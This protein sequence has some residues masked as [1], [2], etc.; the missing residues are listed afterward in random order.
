MTRT[1]RSSAALADDHVRIPGARM[2]FRTN[3]VAPPAAAPTVVLVHGL[4]IS[5]RYMEPL[6]LRL[7]GLCRV[8][9]V[10]L[11]GYGRSSKPRPVLR[12]PGLADALASWMDAMAID[13]AHH[14]GNS[15]GCQILAAFAARHPERVERLVLQGPTMDARHR[16]LAQQA[17]RLSL[18]SVLEAKTL[19]PVAMRDYAAAGVRRAWRTLRI[20][21][22]DRIEENLPRVRAPALVVRGALDPVVPRRWAEEVTRLLP[23]GELREIP[24]APHTLNYTAPL[25]LA[26]VIKPFFGLRGAP[27]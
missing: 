12:I 6:A 7:A 11:P 18:N 22:D 26:R 15:A 16:T 20:A 24:G 13:R 8:Y 17:L 3:A 4:V 10:D 27:A 21:L 19:G 14:V 5:S 23:R 1:R 2:F 9:A 25:E